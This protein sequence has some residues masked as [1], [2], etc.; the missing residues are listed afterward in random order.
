MWQFKQHDYLIQAT[1]PLKKNHTVA[2][3]FHYVNSNTAIS[4]PLFSL[5]SSGAVFVG[6]INVQKQFKNHRI[7]LGTSALG[8]GTNL[9]LQYNLGY[10]FYPRSNNSFSLGAKGYVHTNDGHGSTYFAVLPFL[11]FRP[12][13]KLDFFASYLLNQGNNI[14]EWNGALVNNSPDL[15]TGRFSLTAGYWLTTKAKISL[16]YQNEQKESGWTADHNYNSL[17]VSLKFIP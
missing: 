6:S 3:S 2:A 10:A 12:Q 1:I 13:P 17:F 11:S 8:M 7:D 14:A 16:T 5:D 4:A 9:Q 15:T